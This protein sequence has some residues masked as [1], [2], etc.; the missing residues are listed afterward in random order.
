MKMTSVKPE[1]VT[2]PNLDF[3]SKKKVM[4]RFAKESLKNREV[5]GKA[6]FWRW[7]SLPIF[8]WVRPI[9]AI[10]R[11]NPPSRRMV[12]VSGKYITI[13]LGIWTKSGVWTKGQR[14]EI[15]LANATILPVILLIRRWY[16]AALTCWARCCVSSATLVRTSA[17]IPWTSTGVGPITSQNGSRR[18]CLG[19]Q[20]E[21][22]S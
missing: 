6:Q 12:T 13:R 3:T 17:F 1:G 14:T 4:W 2:I 7:Y 21:C 15:C 5:G 18:T 22:Y 20:A 11:D 16:D 10:L 9:S 8:T 19:E